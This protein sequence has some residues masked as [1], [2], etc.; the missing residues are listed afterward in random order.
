VTRDI[1]DAETK[2]QHRYLRHGQI[3]HLKVKAKKSK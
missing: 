3:V 1:G 2:K